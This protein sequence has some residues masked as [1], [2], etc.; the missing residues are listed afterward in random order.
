VKWTTNLG[1]LDRVNVQLSTTGIGGP[2][3]TMQGGSD[4]L[5]TKKVADVL[6][7]ST[8]TTSARI[9]VLWANPPAG[10][11]ASG[12][13]AG[14]FKIEA[15]FVN[16]T[17]P[18]AGEVWS[19]GSTKTI[20]WASNLGSLEKVE[21][22]LSKDGGATYPILIAGSTLSD[23]KHPVTVSATWGSQSSTRLKITWLKA[24]SVAGVSA[25]FAIQ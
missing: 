7:P 1:P 21:I 10:V 23:G 5:A 9:R 13:N 17:S 18:L 11:S 22:R 16:L 2:F 12:N 24:P 15:P 3:S 19:I 14:N 8:A 6:V 25:S 4:I 20:K